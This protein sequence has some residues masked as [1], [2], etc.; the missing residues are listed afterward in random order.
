MN[1]TN[2]NRIFV[3]ILLASLHFSCVSGKQEDTKQ[4]SE[5]EE[6]AILKAKKELEIG[7]NM[8]GRLLRLW[9]SVEEP[10]L[11]KYVNE[12]ASYVATSS[13]FTD[14]R[15]MVEILDSD[16]VN[17]FACPGGYI[18]L[19]KGAVLNATSEAEIASVL[20]H[21][22]AHVGKEHMLDTLSR[23]N[24][25]EEGKEKKPIPSR[26]LSDDDP[27]RKSHP[28]VSFLQNISLVP[29]RVKCS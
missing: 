1:K 29:S 15:F 16:E 4:Y 5:A 2:Y 12:V 13:P 3:Y 24:K 10:R 26:L 14:R 6:K 20:A 22:I 23:M 18:M 9:G 17:A 19:T 25:E 11:I 21:E 7:R 27:I 8:A 28:L